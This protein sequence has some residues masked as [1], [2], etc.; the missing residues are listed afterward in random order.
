VSNLQKMLL[1]END[2]FGRALL[3]HQLKK[4]I[5]EITT[6]SSF[7][8]E[9]TMSLPYLFRDY[10][11]MPILE[12][13]ALALCHGSTL[14]IGC[15]AGS[16]SL[17]L[18]QKGYDVTALDNSL[19]AIKVCTL[20]GIAKTKNEAILN[21]LGIKF[22]TLLLLMNGIGLVGTLKSLRTYLSH[23]KKLLRPKG[24]ILMDSSNIIY[25]YEKDHDGGHLVPGN[26]SYY[27]EVEYT[28][29]YNGET[30]E[31]FYWLYVDFETLRANCFLEGFNCELVSE[32]EH[33]DYLARLT[34]IE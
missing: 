18:Q 28:L 2:I 23:F 29:K 6:I 30:S 25:M 33:Y 34:P 1:K 5:T 26:L 10:D 13:K 24:Q 4:T 19:G 27:G 7:D 32:G 21:V 20:R 14:D 9:D 11:Q 12:Q 31:P 15:G 16:H 17:Y 22:D 8:E 3:D